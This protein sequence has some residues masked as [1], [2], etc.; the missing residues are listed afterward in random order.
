[1]RGDTNE[2][3][4]SK[5]IRDKRSNDGMR[6]ARPT[7]RR[8]RGDRVP[9]SRNRGCRRMAARCGY[10]GG[11]WTEAALTAR[12]YRGRKAHTPPFLPNEAS[13]NVEEIVFM[14]HGENGLRRL[15]KNDKWL[16]FSRLEGKGTERADRAARLQG[17]EGS[18]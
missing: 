5:R 13:C 16:R 15:Q 2:H 7:I 6:D 8:E 17:G 11:E 14:C 3:A 9:R 4:F 12:G 18:Q 1:M 10:S